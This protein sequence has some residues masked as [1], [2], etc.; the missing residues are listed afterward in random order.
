ML[1][2]ALVGIVGSGPLAALL[3]YV[4]ISER[5]E[6]RK[7]DAWTQGMLERVVSALNN[8]STAQNG[9]QEILKAVSD[10]LMLAQAGRPRRG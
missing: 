8:S 4:W 9:N 10:Y 2:Q 6:R 5:D 3:F 1:A 7:K